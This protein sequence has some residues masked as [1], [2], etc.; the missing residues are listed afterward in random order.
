MSE[1]PPLNDAPPL[2][3]AAHCNSIRDK[4]L[5]GLVLFTL[6][7]TGEA[8]AGDQATI[9]NATLNPDVD[10]LALAKYQELESPANSTGLPCGVR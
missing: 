4:M 5:V 2:N 3:L 10:S 8:L 1:F 6:A 7:Q 9:A